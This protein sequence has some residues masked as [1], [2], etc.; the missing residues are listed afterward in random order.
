MGEVIHMP[1]RHEHFGGCP[2]CGRMTGF[3]H[4]GRNHWAYCEEHRFTWCFGWNLLDGWRHETEEDW[5]R[6]TAF[7]S[8]YKIVDL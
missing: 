1:E 8:H 4:I 6:N 2:R 3:L 7:L 5:I